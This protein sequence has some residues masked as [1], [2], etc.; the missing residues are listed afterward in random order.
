MATA[1]PKRSDNACLNPEGT[2]TTRSDNADL[3][4]GGI[5]TTRS[6]SAES[7]WVRTMTT[8]C[9]CGASFDPVRKHQ[10]FCSRKCR[11]RAYE[12]RPEAT[13]RRSKYSKS[14][15]GRAAQQRYQDSGATAANSRAY[16]YR[17]YYEYDKVLAD[18]VKCYGYP[19]V[20]FHMVFGDVKGKIPLRN[21]GT[22]REHW[23]RDSNRA[24]WRGWRRA[25]QQHPTDR[26]WTEVRNYLWPRYVN[27]A[28]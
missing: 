28:A 7:P 15:K 26:L 17:I 10:L 19:Q 2:A 5:G 20:S 8:L 18:L 24:W 27:V 16:R 13:T 3:N 22:M 23:T 14:S 1:Q 9:S 25:E 4:P 6:D 11:Q 21:V 12:Q